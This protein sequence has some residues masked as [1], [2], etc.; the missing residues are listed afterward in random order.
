MR[1]VMIVA[2][3]LFIVGISNCYA[4]IKIRMLPAYKTP[5]YI[6]KKGATKVIDIDAW[7]EQ[8]SKE[9][10]VIRPGAFTANPA[11]DK[12]VFRAAFGSLKKEMKSD[13]QDEE[14]VLKAL[15]TAWV[16]IAVKGYDETHKEV[17]F[18]EQNLIEKA[19]NLGIVQIFTQPIGA[20]IILDNKYE[21]STPTDTY[22]W[23]AFGKHQITLVKEGYVSIKKTIEILPNPPTV[24]LIK[25]Q[26]Q[27]RVKRQ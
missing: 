27:I 11:Q 25:E 13:G 7:V 6:T 22:L 21:E 4:Q 19:S 1:T 23:L 5:S 16:D 20:R 10:N 2:S 14:K 15:F 3:T 26:M 17:E 8:I 9:I 18:S 24:P 12:I